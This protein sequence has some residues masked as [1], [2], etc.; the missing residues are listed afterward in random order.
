M[1]RFLLILALSFLFSIPSAISQDR[2]CGMNHGELQLLTERLIENKKLVAESSNLRSSEILY[3][4]LKFHIMATSAGFGG[5]NEEEILQ[6]VCR[7]NE[8]YFDQEVQFFV[9]GEFNY[10][11]NTAAYED[12]RSAAGQLQLS[13][14]KNQNFGRANIFICLAAG[15]IPNVGPSAGFYSPQ[16]D[17]IVV[18]ISD[19]SSSNETLTHELGHFFSLQ[20][21]FA[22][23]DFSPYDPSMHSNPAPSETPSPYNP[24]PT[25]NMDRTGNCKN[26][27]TA[28][29]RLC[30][31]N[32][33]YLLSQSF[34]SGNCDYN[35]QILDPCGVL[36]VPPKENYM[37][38]FFGCDQ[39]FSQG[40]KDLIRADITKRL[41]QEGTLNRTFKPDNT[42]PV[43]D[44]VV[45]VNPAM[46]EVLDYNFNVHF[47]WEPVP[48]A[49]KYILDVDRFSSFNT[50]NQRV[51]T[52]TNGAEIF[53]L[54][55]DTKYFWRVYAYNE[56]SGCLGWSESF[57]FTTGEGATSTVG[58]PSIA[59]WQVDPNPV[60]SGNQITIQIS[61][62]NNLDAEINVTDITGRHLIKTSERL[63]SGSNSISLNTQ[64]LQQGIYI[65][66][67]QTKEGIL[68]EKLIINN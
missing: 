3:I 67:I 13:N 25:E 4:P 41:N 29:D 14:G 64:N 36:V 12:P 51:F 11:N 63:R 33:D 52:G 57:E 26:C 28:G 19:V 60:L 32:P 7:L 35:G 43:V 16:S 62:Q 45:A 1:S 58:I 5:I 31:T 34:S 6:Q 24:R 56:V 59:D 2:S 18:R 54:K 37:S 17:W 53:D 48:N 9:E 47:E 68:S 23:W 55:A 8:D 39:V 66:S 65:V 61:V 20:H 42:N 22:G 15:D 46:G 50:A 30:D 27:E 40:Q 44:P 49:T 38:Y 21:T 10:I